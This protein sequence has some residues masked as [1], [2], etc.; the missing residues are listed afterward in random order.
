MVKRR[1][2]RKLNNLDWIMIMLMMPIILLA[3]FPIL[4]IPVGFLLLCWFLK[5]ISEIVETISGWFPEK[6]EK[7]SNYVFDKSKLLSYNKQKEDYSKLIEQKKEDVLETPYDNL[8]EKKIIYRGRNYYLEGNVNV[9]CYNN[10]ECNAVVSGSQDYEVNIKFDKHNTMKNASCTCPYYQENNLYCK[11]IYATLL[12]CCKKEK[13]IT[14]TSQSKYSL[15][16]QI[17]EYCDKIENLI[18]EVE[19]EYIT[20]ENED[21]ELESLYYEIIEYRDDVD[22]YRNKNFSDVDIYLVKT[23]EETHQAC[24]ELYFQFMDLCEEIQEQS[25]EEVDEETALMI[26]ALGYSMYKKRKEEDEE[27]NERLEEREYLKSE[28]GLTDYQIDLVESGEYEPSQF[29]EEEIEEDD[30]YS[31]D[32]NDF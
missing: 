32:D 17:L 6:K 19:A 4:W 22:L 10:L 28:W 26:G 24:E 31:E 3:A 13:S 27:A 30:Y 16:E 23:L 11:H 14:D 29:S 25:I 9:C 15:L 2:S 1:N 18:D 7:K 8:F 21:E 12:K 5:K 20:V